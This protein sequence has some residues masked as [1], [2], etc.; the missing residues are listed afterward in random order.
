MHVMLS[1]SLKE[2]VI[3]TGSLEK[4][5]KET[6]DCLVKLKEL[7]GSLRTGNPFK[8]GGGKA[9]DLKDGSLSIS[10]GHK[11][12]TYLEIRIFLIITFSG[13]Q[14]LGEFGN[15]SLILRNERLIY[16]SSIGSGTSH[17]YESP[18]TR[19]NV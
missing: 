15:K 16:P 3:I 6:I 5:P 2:V 18:K 7:L 10:I 1:L 4:R 12:T 14:F 17:R 8:V 11:T 9:S 13:K 19:H